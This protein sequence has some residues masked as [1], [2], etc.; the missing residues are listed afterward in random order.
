[1]TKATT[2]IIAVGKKG[3]ALFFI[4]V[5]DGYKATAI[6]IE[7]HKIFSVGSLNTL[8]KQQK[9]RTLKEINGDLTTVFTKILLAKKYPLKKI[10]NPKAYLMVPIELWQQSITD[11]NQKQKEKHIT[12]TDLNL[13][14]QIT[15]N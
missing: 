12:E 15:N 5:P 13:L 14:H 10:P 8:N 3:I 9:L 1:M 4:G 11:W 6:K 7:K 2:E